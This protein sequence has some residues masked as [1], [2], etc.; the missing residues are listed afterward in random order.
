MQLVGNEKNRAQGRARS[1]A[2]RGPKVLEKVSRER[3]IRIRIPGFP[4][5]AVV[6]YVTLQSL[7]KVIPQLPELKYRHCLGI[8]ATVDLLMTFEDLATFEIEP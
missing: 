7:R 8:A 1:A 4:L 3:L 6:M 5:T 2:S